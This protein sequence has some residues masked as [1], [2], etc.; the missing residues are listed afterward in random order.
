MS[1]T[2]PPIDTSDA[3]PVGIPDAANESLADYGRR[4]WAGVRTGDLGSLPIVVGL[5]LIAI[6]FQSQNDR[7][8]TAGNF[9]NLI[10]QMAA[11]TI[12]GMGIVFVLLLGEI[13]LSVGYVSG[14]AG[15]TTALLMNPDGHNQFGAIPAIIVALAVGLGIGVG[16]GLI[17]TKIGVP[18]FVVTLAGLLAWNG[19]V[20][21][22][23]GDKGTVIIQN[24]LV[25]GFANDFLPAATAWIVLALGIALYA[26]I[27]L[28]QDR[29]RRRAG[30]PTEP[31]ALYALR[32]I[33]PAPARGVVLG[34]SHARPG[35][36]YRFLLL[37]R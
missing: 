32:V 12:I 34:V 13:D 4:W 22:L 2:T 15:V 11:I 17:I 5:I 19:V 16:Q 3:A 6:I 1:T 14:V 8:L 28:M 26:G 31:A 25:V 20:L 37:T 27:L 35:L 36:P 23:I 7:F 30:L 18:S 10:V 21:L 24:D 33:G 9:V 29:S